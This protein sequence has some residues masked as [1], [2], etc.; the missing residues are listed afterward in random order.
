MGPIGEFADSR[1][2]GLVGG[3]DGISLCVGEMKRARK[4]FS[5]A[6]RVVRMLVEGNPFPDTRV[7]KNTYF[8]CVYAR[9]M[10]K[11]GST[12]AGKR[13]TVVT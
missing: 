4:G 3:K 9:I 5:R 13:T 6:E 1:S 11:N 8:E 12:K 10:S 2:V 7:S